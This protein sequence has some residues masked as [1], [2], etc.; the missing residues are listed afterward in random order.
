MIR[1]FQVCVLA[2][3]STGCATTPVSSSLCR[4]LGCIE[5]DAGIEAP[6]GARLEFSK[7]HYRNSAID[8]YKYVRVES[9]WSLV[10]YE[11]ALSEKCRTGNGA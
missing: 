6:M 1:I 4:T 10:F 5:P 2:V 7:C 9:G 3:M 8:T 11:S